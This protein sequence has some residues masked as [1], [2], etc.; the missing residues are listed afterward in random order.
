MSEFTGET[1]GDAVIPAKIKHEKCTSFSDIRNEGYE[2]F[3]V[4]PV[5]VYA[6]VQQSLIDAFAKDTSVDKPMTVEN[7]ILSFED[8]VI[9][10]CGWWSTRLEI[11]DKVNYMYFRA[12]MQKW[13][14]MNKAAHKVYAATSYGVPILDPIMAAAGKAPS[15]DSFELYLLNTPSWSLVPKTM[16]KGVA[17]IPYAAA[18][19]C[20]ELV[21]S[22][23][24]EAMKE[25]VKGLDEYLKD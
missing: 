22:K 15:P 19:S 16:R 23:P 4:G 8:V 9:K 13:V 6:R 20:V 18:P 21:Y 14:F 10:P 3:S 24:V 2:I 5:Y 1:H 11:M 25:V 17:G 12:W 7:S